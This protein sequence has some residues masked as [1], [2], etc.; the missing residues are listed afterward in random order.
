[1]PL[2]PFA[3]TGLWIDPRTDQRNSASP[4]WTRQGTGSWVHGGG[5]QRGAVTRLWR[6]ADVSSVSYG[7]A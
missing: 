4:S 3:S 1:V 7:T 2:A 6:Q 5:Q